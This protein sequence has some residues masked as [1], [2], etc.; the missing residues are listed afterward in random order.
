MTGCIYSPAQR[1]YHRSAADIAAAV[2]TYVDYCLEHG[3]APLVAAPVRPSP[4]RLFN[5]A[6]VPRERW[7]FD[8]QSVD[9]LNALPTALEALAAQR[10]I[11][12]FDANSCA[13]PGADGLHWT[14]ESHQV[15]AAALA[16]L[17]TTL[18]LAKSI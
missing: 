9:V 11:A 17:I 3:T 7:N 18:P 8:D 12:F 16:K 2:F 10:N 14:A 1:Y 13:T 6:I 4:A 15:F 5:E